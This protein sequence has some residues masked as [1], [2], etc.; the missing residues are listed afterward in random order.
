MLADLSIEP[1]TLVSRSDELI[2]VSP[3]VLD[4]YSEV[5]VMD[6]FAETEDG[7]GEDSDDEAA[8][9]LGGIHAKVFVQENG[10]DTAITIGSRQRDAPCTAHR[11]QRRSVC[12]ADRKAVQGRQY[13]R[14][15]RTA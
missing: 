12:D 15:L 5:S 4:R 6:E 2:A 13:L 9:P 7:E 14:H 11:P 10:W 1:P 8:H 3:R